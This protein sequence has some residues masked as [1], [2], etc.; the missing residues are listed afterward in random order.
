M[1]IVPARFR[2]KVRKM[3]GSH[4]H[5][6]GAKKKH[7]GTG[8]QSGRGGSSKFYSRKTSAILEKQ[9]TGK[10]GFVSLSKTEVK[11]I[12]VQDLD[13]LARSR[14]VKEVDVTAMG[15]GKVLG[16]GKITIP[17][18]VK[19][20]SFSAGAKSKIEAAGGKAV[21][22]QEIPAKKS[23]SSDIKVE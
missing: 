16:S 20:K 4:T 12:D 7:R 5:G 23:G 13:Q 15:F 3:R 10:K 1:I 11:T 17:L 18:V 9:I 22:P 19:A 2:K 21:A 8:S 14:N 6:W